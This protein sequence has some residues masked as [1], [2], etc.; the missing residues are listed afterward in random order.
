MGPGESATWVSGWGSVVEI[1]MSPSEDF[2]NPRSN[3]SPLVPKAER[4]QF[5]RA[6]GKF[7]AT[8]PSSVNIASNLRPPA[9]HYFQYQSEVV[10]FES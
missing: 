1:G 6:F 7:F 3:A 2:G 8:P 10:G 4:I 9:I 5:G